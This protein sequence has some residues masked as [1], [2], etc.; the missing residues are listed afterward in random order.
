MAFFPIYHYRIHDDPGVRYFGDQLDFFDPWNDLNSSPTAVVVA[1]DRFHWV[2]QPRQQRRSSNTKSPCQ[3]QVARAPNVEKFRIQFNVAGF[4]PETI[5]THVEGQKV[6][7]LAKQEERLPDG[8]YNIR[9]VRKSCPLPE[10]ADTNQLVSYVTPNHVL[11][12]EVPIKN[13]EL[14]RRQSEIK[15]EN[16]NLSQFGSNRDPQFNYNA[17]LADSG[18]QPQIIN[19]DDNKKQLAMTLDMKNY[20]ADEIKVS[21]K[22]NELI[23]KGEQRNKNN[24]YSER[25]FFFKSVALPPGAQVEQLQ[26]YLTPEGQLKIEVPFEEQK[27][28]A[29]SVENQKEES[30]PAEEQNKN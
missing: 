9:E 5:K 15:S 27:E 4:N 24:N 7:I 1:P 21:V 26:S 29:Q 14:E 23:V 28:E 18:F 11:V 20:G 30:K 25:S 17:F 16:Q 10:H 19:K 2:N 8:D 13:P 22:N 12:I 3:H 6:V